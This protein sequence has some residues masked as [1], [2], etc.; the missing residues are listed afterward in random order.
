MIDIEF[1]ERIARLPRDEHDR[2]IPWFAAIVDGRVDLRLADEVKLRRAVGDGRCWI[3]GERFGSGAHHARARSFIVGPLAAFNR[4]A[5]EPPS[6]KSCAL[7][8]CRVCPFLAR[9]GK[10]RRAGNMPDEA[11]AAPSE[12]IL[13]NPGVSLIWMC[14]RYDVETHD[15]GLLFRLPYPTALYAYAEG[16]P[17]L[18]H[19]LAD[20]MDRAEATAR[21]GAAADGVP[22]VDI[23]A[24]IR[25]GRTLVRTRIR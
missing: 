22:P 7:Y 11:H 8:A 4:A 10:Q 3:C 19:Q 13:D 17:A 9:P 23:D 20:A 25:V 14:R 2:P 6:H 16:T 15:G 5:P 18:T 1:P 12:P 21:A 24:M